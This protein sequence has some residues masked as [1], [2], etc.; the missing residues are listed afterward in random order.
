MTTSVQ[1][2]GGVYQAVA[3][4]QT[5]KALGR[6]GGKLNDVLEGILVVPATTSP[7]AVQIKDGAD[8]AITVFAGGASSVSNLV[9]FYLPLGGIK[10]KT[11]AWQITTGSDVSVV[12]AGRFT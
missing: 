12:A 8:T 7:G 1:L 6:D 10:S 5:A 4:G 3:A 2:A 11:G 9:S